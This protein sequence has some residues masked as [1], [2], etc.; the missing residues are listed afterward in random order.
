MVECPSREANRAQ[1]TCKS[2]DCERRGLCC[3]C[4]AYHRGKSG[5]PACLRNLAKKEG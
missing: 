3:E 5:L 4:V 2:E 1:C